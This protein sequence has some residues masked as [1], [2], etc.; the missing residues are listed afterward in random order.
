MITSIY[1]I[2]NFVILQSRTVEEGRLRSDR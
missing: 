2:I 1:Q